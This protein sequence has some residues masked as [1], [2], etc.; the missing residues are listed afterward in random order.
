MGEPVHDFES[1]AHVRWDCKY[2]AVLVSRYYKR[3]CTGI[4]KGGSARY[5]KSHAGIRLGGK[6]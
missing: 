2:H 3:C 6:G 5:F 4:L 1:L